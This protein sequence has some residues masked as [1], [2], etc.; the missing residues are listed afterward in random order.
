MQKQ[1]KSNQVRKKQVLVRPGLESKMKPVP[2]SKRPNT[3]KAE[4]D[5]KVGRITDG[6][7]NIGR[8]AAILCAKESDNIVISYL[9][10][11]SDTQQTQRGAEQYTKCQI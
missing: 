10:K 11:N 9:G 5:G 4:L 2:V 7:S 8:T 3:K 6:D 1:S